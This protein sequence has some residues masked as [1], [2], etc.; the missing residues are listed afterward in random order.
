MS[1]LMF[2]RPPREATKTLKVRVNRC[3]ITQLSNININ[4]G[5]EY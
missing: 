3:K 5:D 2:P 1:Q 4:Q